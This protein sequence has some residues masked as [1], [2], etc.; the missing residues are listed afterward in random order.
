MVRLAHASGVAPA[1]I[2][3]YD[4][5]M[6]ARYEADARDVEAAE[7]LPLA[8]AAALVYTRLFPGDRVKDVKTLDLVGLAIS[9]LIP[10]YQRDM[11]SGA[12]RALEPTDIARGRFARGASRLEFP[13]RLPLTFLLVS[14]RELYPAIEAIVRDPACPILKMCRRPQPGYSSAR[15]A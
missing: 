11:K 2:G 1:G 10:L 14:R 9:T 3:F 5:R 13:D 4:G 15:G 6:A 12:V 8:R 7:Y